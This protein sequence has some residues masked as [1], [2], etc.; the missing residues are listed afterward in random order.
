MNQL[1]NSTITENSPSDG[2]EPAAPRSVESVGLL[3]EMIRSFTTLSRT[4]NLSHAVKELGST[5]QTVRRHIAQLE[6]VKGVELFSVVDRQYFLTEAGR[7]ALPEAEE[8]LAR[9]R[10]W[11]G[12]QIENVNGLRRFRIDMPGEWTFW[13]QQQP[14]CEIWTSERALLRECF[15]AWA[16][17]GGDIEHEAMSHVRPY[18]MVYRDS[19]SG[20]ICV[21]IGDESSFVSWYGWAH[22]RSSIGR[23]IEKLPSGDSLSSLLTEPFDDVATHQS[24]R[25]EHVFVQL[26]RETDGPRVPLSYKRLL[27]GGRFP[28]GSFAL[29]AAVDRCKEIDIDGLD[30]EAAYSMPEDLIMPALPN[31]LKYEP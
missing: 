18:F 3:H 16:L 20:W 9:G 27:L 19:P 11:L 28:D 4:L 1:V 2:S 31:E 24:A 10:A 5:R 8:I 22:A 7:R 21:E 26:P 25:M 6:E 14:M 29:I 30:P 13:L 15:R 23:E 12:G 17:A